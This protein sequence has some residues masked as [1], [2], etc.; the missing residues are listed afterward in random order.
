[1]KNYL[2]HFV[3]FLISCIIGIAN[4]EADNYIIGSQWV[5][6]IS[7]AYQQGQF[8]DFLNK[9]E[10][11]YEKGSQTQEWELLRN[12]E[13]ELREQYLTQE[14]KDR[15][16][17]S[18]KNSKNYMNELNILK[19]ERNRL[20]LLI[21][22]EHPDDFVSKVI[23]DIKMYDFETITDYE[24]GD[25]GSQFDEL[26]FKIRVFDSLISMALLDGEESDDY[27]GLE[28]ISSEDGEK[29]HYVVGLYEFQQMLK[30]VDD[31]EVL[32]NQILEEMSKDSVGN[33]NKHN[34][35]YLQSLGK[36]SRQPQNEAEKGV[37]VIMKNFQ[38]KQRELIKKHQ[39]GLQQ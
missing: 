11:R 27:T 24:I 15:L 23:N 4:L 10:V 1:M 3:C 14:G 26:F 18:L 25:I 32:K 13:K 33:A 37:A 19:K 6:N 5:K 8:S 35:R 16:K 21:A 29:Y 36:N 39:L 28:K 2:S 9:L 7:E 31:Q 12:Q 17:E 22:K 38:Q 34:E 30:Q 20:L